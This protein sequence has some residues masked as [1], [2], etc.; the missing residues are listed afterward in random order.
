[1]IRL[2]VARC[3]QEHVCEH[4]KG[5]VESRLFGE[6]EWKM[7]YFL[8]RLDLQGPGTRYFV[9]LVRTELKELRT[10]C[11]NGWPR[12]KKLVVQCPFFVLFHPSPWLPHLSTSLSRSLPF[13]LLRHLVSFALVNSMSLSFLSLYLTDLPQ[14]H[15]PQLGP[16]WPPHL[17]PHGSYPLLHISPFSNTTTLGKGRSKAAFRSEWLKTDWTC[18]KFAGLSHFHIKSIAPLDK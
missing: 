11:L 18:K 7:L 13:L 12:S 9:V 5:V 4:R 15:E 6:S 17:Q 8:A 14:P 3:A 1:M 2:K 10:S 16:Y